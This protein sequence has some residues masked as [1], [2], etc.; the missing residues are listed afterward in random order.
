MSHGKRR[1][2]EKGRGR[3]EGRGGEGRKLVEWKN[4]RLH[5]SSKK[6]QQN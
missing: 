3:E 5:C 4:L 6:V 2:E 1:K